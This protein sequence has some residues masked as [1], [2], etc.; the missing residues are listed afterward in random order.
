[1]KIRDIEIGIEPNHLW[2]I[3]VSLLPQKVQVGLQPRTATVNDIVNRY[4][5]R[6]EASS[7]T[8]LV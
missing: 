4:T 1:M 8:K 2:R 6:I 5:Q 3:L 7:A